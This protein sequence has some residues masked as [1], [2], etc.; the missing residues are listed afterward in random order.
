MEPRPPNLNNAVIVLDD[1]DLDKACDGIITALT[2]L[3]GQWCCGVGRLFA[4]ARVYDALLEKLLTRLHTLKLGDALDSTSEMGPIAHSVHLEHLH[5]LILNLVGEGGRCNS[6]TALPQLNGCF[7]APTI[8]TGISPSLAGQRELFG[9]VC[10][11]HSFNTD[12]EVVH[13]ANDTPGMLMSNIFSTST[14]RCMRIGREISASMVMLN[15]VE[16]GFEIEEEP[17]LSFWGESGCGEDGPLS[18][19]TRFFSGNR[20]VGFTGSSDPPRVDRPPRRNVL[21]FRQRYFS[22]LRII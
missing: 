7:L 18:T 2:I 16:F 4:H 12:S 6:R 9:P 17:V 1:A 21:D 14:A 11:M 20:V 8:I 19:L 15:G 3:N 22:R 10:T 13:L 5:S